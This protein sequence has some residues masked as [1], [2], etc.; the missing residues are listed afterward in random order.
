[1]SSFPIGDF[2]L[3]LFPDAEVGQGDPEE[4]EEEDPVLFGDILLAFV[5]VNLICRG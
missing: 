1:M 2:S 5:E 4:D 3:S